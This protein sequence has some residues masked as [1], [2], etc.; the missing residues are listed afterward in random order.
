MTD[1]DD[2]REKHGIVGGTDAV[3]SIRK[4]VDQEDDDE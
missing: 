4:Q 3:E 2:T 1:N